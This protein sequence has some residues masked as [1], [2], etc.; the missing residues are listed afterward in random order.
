MKRWTSYQ[1][2]AVATLV[3]TIAVVLWGAIVRA[4]GSGAGCGSHWPTCNGD[5]V[6]RAPSTATLIELFHRATSGGLVILT[7]VMVVSAF[8]TFPPR[9]PARAAGVGSLFFLATEAAVGAGLVLLELVAENKS[10]ARGWWMAAHLINTFV[11][12]AWVALS[13][14]FGW[15][16]TRPRVRGPHATKLAVALTSL[17]A[18]GV[19]GAIAALG[20]TLFPAQSLAHR[21]AM[22]LSPGA[23]VLLRLRVLHPFVAGAT[24]TYLLWMTASL[25]GRAPSPTSKRLGGWLGGLVLTQVVVGFANLAL[26]APT[27][28]QIVHLFLA[29]A[30]WIA[31]VLLAAATFSVEAGA[32]ASAPAGAEAARG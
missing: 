18:V 19:T 28:M 10:L 31:T 14:W 23:H 4:T 9:H 2:L 26:L 1:R 11:L 8:R 6:P 12:L 22:D 3:S 21:V 20:D 29:D 15:S 32:P 24:A 13:V 16:D 27:W 25:A 5:I 17:L 7:I 30:V